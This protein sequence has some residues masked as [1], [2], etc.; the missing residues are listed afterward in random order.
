[1][2]ELTC[3][4]FYMWLT[5][6]FEGIPEANINLFYGFLKYV[7]FD[8]PTSSKQQL[9]KKHYCLCVDDVICYSNWRDT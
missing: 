9:E 4:S 8:H 6:G 3:K 1:M 2:H 7:A 5:N